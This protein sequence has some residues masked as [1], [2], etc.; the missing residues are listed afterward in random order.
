M[1]GLDSYYAEGETIATDRVKRGRLAQLVERRIYTANVGGSS[2]S[3]STMEN[4]GRILAFT[5]F[6]FLSLGLLFNLMPRF[7]RIPGDIYI[8]KFGF[9]VY[10]PWLSSLVISVILTVFFNFFRR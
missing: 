1:D 4:I 2:P 5:G 6:I 7:P 10:I 3:P 9:R 8:D